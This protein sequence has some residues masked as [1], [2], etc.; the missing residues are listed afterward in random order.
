MLSCIKEILS[1]GIVLNTAFN[2]NGYTM[3]RTKNHAIEIFNSTEL[4]YLGLGN[5]LI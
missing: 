2:V 5:S 4:K 1:I 3:I